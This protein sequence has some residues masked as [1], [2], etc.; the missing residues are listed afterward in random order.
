MK[1]RTDDYIKSVQLDEGI[2]TSSDYLIE[3]NLEEEAILNAKIH[4]LKLILSKLNYL[5][6]QGK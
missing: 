5:T 2:V 6:I 3:L 4:E 1:T